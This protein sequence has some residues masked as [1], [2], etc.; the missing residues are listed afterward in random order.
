V[1]AVVLGGVLAMRG[2]SKPAAPITLLQLDPRSGDVVR[3]IRD[4]TLGCPCGANLF[5]INGTLWERGGRQ[6][7][8]VVVRDMSTGRLQRVTAAPRG[9][10]DGA[11][12]FGSIWLL[13]NIL[14]VKSGSTADVVERRD[15]LSG[16][17]TATVR[18]PNPI[19]SGS[20]VETGTVAV[21]NGALWV[22][23]GDAVLNRI[24]PATNK[25]TGRFASGALETQILLPTGG[26]E[27][28]CECLYHKVL[29]YDARTRTGK[30]FH[31]FQQPWHL[32]EIKTA[33][34]PT[35]WLMDEQGATLTQIDPQT[36]KPKQPLGLNGTPTE[37]TQ[38]GD[39]IWV[40]AG[41]VVDRIRLNGHKRTSIQLPKGMNATGIA[42]DAATGR[43]WVNSSYP[44]PSD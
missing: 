8:L 3:T 5:A 12:G 36:G 35:L 41:T 15:E 1:A 11:V 31:F 38:L 19:N 40:A 24:D 39:S 7:N 27:W 18:L 22:L 10:I 42:A 21:G 9:S 13:R 43:L 29:R 44:P 2:S 32:V 20:S 16:R 25:L 26:Y 14:D 30:T 17:V 23:Q 28:I 6:G 33:N 37:A 4:G 34:G